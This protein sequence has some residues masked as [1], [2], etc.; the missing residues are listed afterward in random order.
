M[1]RN[2]TTAVLAALLLASVTTSQAVAQPAPPSAEAHLNQAH[3]REIFFDY[4]QV[5]LGDRARG[6]G[7]ETGGAAAA[8]IRHGI[9]PKTGGQN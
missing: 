3:L 7:V 2:R 6:A 9:V 5:R 8:A 4:D 1:P